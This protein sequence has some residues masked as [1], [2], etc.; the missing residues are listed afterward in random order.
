M[1][2]IA[3]AWLLVPSILPVAA[4]QPD[5]ASAGRE[6]ENVAAF[7]RLYGVVRY[8]Y[9]SD[10][11][12][13]LDWNRFAVH[14]VARVH[15]A[16][17]A[18]ALAR[19]L[20][21]LFAPLGPGIEVGRTLRA[22]ASARDTG[23]PLVAWRHLGPG[24]AGTAYASRRTHRS[25]SAGIEELR[26]K[27]VRLR[28]QVRARVQGP[29]DGAALWLRVDRPKKT[30]GFFDNMSDRT[31]REAEWREYRI[32][33][34]VDGDAEALAFGVMAFGQASADFDAFEL[35]QPRGKDACQPL[36]ISDPGFEAP[37]DS[38]RGWFRAGSARNALVSQ[39]AEAAPE[40][41]QFL[42]L[43][44]P[45]SAAYDGFANVMQTLGSSELFAGAQPSAGA[46]AD[47]DLGS[48]LK[49][50]VP[51]ALGDAV[52]KGDAAREAELGALR[53]A[54]AALDSPSGPPARN[55]R[56]ADVVVAWNIFRHFYPY[57]AEAGVDWDA[58]LR[59]QLGAARSAETRAEQRRALREL[60]A[61]ARDGHGSVND[62]RSPEGRAQL[63]IQ[64]G[65]VEG[66]LVVTA[67]SVPELAPLGAVLE[68]LDGVPAAQRLAETMRL[69]SGAE[70]WKRVRALAEITRGPAGTSAALVIETG[71]G[72]REVT[73]ERAG[74]QAPPEPRPAPATEL[75]PRIWYV[76][77][78]RIKMAELQLLLPKLATARGVIFDMRGY[79]GDAGAG[80]LPHLIAEPEDDRWMHVARLVGP[81]GQSAGWQDLGW[82]V[83]PQ[84]P[85]LTGRIVFLTD[86]RAISY[87]ESV[88]GYVT[89]HKLGTIVGGATAGTNGNVAMFELP[90]GFRVGFTGMLVTRHDGRSQHHLVG[91]KP[92]IPLEPTLAGLRAGRDEL[93]ERASGLIREDR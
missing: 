15:D 10:A 87:A 48:G 4:A 9:P 39:I 43:A 65:F 63:P 64:L 77:L 21:P 91:V 53:A 38:R 75:E 44:P 35:C 5:A 68:Q 61:D 62:L 24:F 20:E 2:R 76:D 52:A 13:G 27:P 93:L 46:H 58:R 14:G 60:V 32:D 54:L 69:T 37:L 66:R 16:R 59:P 55:S 56:L 90:S 49:A 17:D 23:E 1:R 79:P 81:F 85:R 70:Q 51:L 6:I 83:K 71:A 86:G 34:V 84:A 67:T 88:M 72:R 11:A 33:G 18:S 36:A 8:F 30:M 89:D 19:A 50:R 80:I 73:L 12:A 3:L 28:A 74:S 41:R 82:N 57:L 7:A 29:G 47:F 25:E 42:R 22:P 26:G 40:G 92:D 78:T 45:P 31:I